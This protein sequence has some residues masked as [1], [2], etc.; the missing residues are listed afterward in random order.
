MTDEIPSPPRAGPAAIV[1]IRVTRM[2]ETCQRTTFFVELTTDE[3]FTMTPCCHRTGSVYNDFEGL[4]VEEARDR[5]LTEA[6]EWGDFL[7]MEVEPYVEDG[8]TY[9]ASFPLETYTTQRELGESRLNG[10]DE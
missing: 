10:E 2:W 1:R 4:S 3:G 6:L 9:E 8:V 7:C 5:A